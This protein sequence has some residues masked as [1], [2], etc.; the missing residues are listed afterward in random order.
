MM[1]WIVFCRLFHCPRKFTFHTL[2]WCVQRC[3]GNGCTILNYVITV[4]LCLSVT[5]Q[6]VWRSNITQQF[7]KLMQKAVLYVPQMQSWAAVCCGHPLPP[8]ALLVTLANYLNSL[9]MSKFV[10]IMPELLH[11]LKQHSPTSLIHRQPAC[12]QLHIR[13]FSFQHLQNCLL[14]TNNDSGSKPIRKLTWKTFW[15][16]G[17]FIIFLQARSTVRFVLLR[18]K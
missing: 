9:R 10:N 14:N 7:S 4:A 5:I 12:T 3:F 11:R 2:F 16:F 15:S 6:L 17:W 18:A 1:L 13:S 8:L